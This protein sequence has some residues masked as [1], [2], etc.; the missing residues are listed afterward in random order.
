MV[1]RNAWLSLLRGA[2][3]AGLAAI[4]SAQDL[5]PRRWTHLPLGTNVLGVGYVFT[6]GDISFDPVLRIEQA[7]VELHTLLFSYTRYFDLAGTTARIDA[8]V[9]VQSG[10][11]TGQLDGT[12]ARVEREGLADP[13]LRFSTN[14]LGAP[15]LDGREFAEFQRANPVTT[16]VGAG[17]EVRLPLGEYMDDKL[18]NLG[19]NR[20]VVTPQL[21]VLHREEQWSFELT[22][23]TFFYT[24]NHDFFGG[25][26][27]EQDP[28]FAVQTHVVRVFDGGFWVSLGAAYGWGGESTING[29][30]KDDEKRNVLYGGSFGFR[31]AETQSV[32]FAY[33]RTDSHAD[34]G[35]DTNSFLI[36][37]AIRF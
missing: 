36:S 6:E 33:A 1:P 11:W 29:V 37:W 28:L 34:T 22:G 5:E 2:S 35:S 14:L 26:N 13:V 27:L 15:A 16:A 3:V 20:F 7:G 30:E 10:E 9:P 21:G 17:L 8:F 18:I 25:N 23:S 24:E 32:R 19:Q 4:A 31:L 12:P